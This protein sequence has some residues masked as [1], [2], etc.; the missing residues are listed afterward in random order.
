[1]LRPLLKVAAMWLIA[2]KLLSWLVATSGLGWQIY[3]ICDQ[4]FKYPTK[5]DITIKI[6]EVE[7]KPTLMVHFIFRGPPW[8]NR[9][10][11][12]LTLK[13]VDAQWPSA[14]YVMCTLVTKSSTPWHGV[15]YSCTNDKMLTPNGR[16][17]EFV[18]SMGFN[19]TANQFLSVMS[20]YV[21]V[22]HHIPL[23]MDSNPKLIVR[24][25]D[26][27]LSA[28][29]RYFEMEYDHTSVKKLPHPYSSCLDYI[30]HFNVKNSRQCWQQCYKQDILNKFHV[31]PGSEFL[32]DEPTAAKY[33]DIEVFDEVSL[34]ETMKYKFGNTC[35][36]KCKQ[37]EPCVEHFFA[38]SEVESSP[39]A[40][41]LRFKLLTSNRPFTY[42]E[43][44]ELITV[45]DFVVYV[46]GSFAFWLGLAPLSLMMSAM[47][48]CHRKRSD[49]VRKREHARDMRR[50]AVFFDEAMETRLTAILD[51]MSKLEKRL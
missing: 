5:T 23:V 47:Q 24:R 18:L 36:R 8:T 39:L 46:L 32:V 31:W 19:F 6:P 29:E 34:N 21:A 49:Y 1:M 44:K 40:G 25:N 17:M 16:V 42:S 27:S 50:L 45:V 4:Y 7:K 48:V 13:S 51:R 15:I 38:I 22:D 35:I 26:H 28:I 9:D 2:W 43:H 3:F 14:D 30:T 41:K 11:P 20:I 12:H 37:A 33:P 10:T